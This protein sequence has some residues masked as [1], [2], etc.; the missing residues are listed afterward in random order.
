MNMF[1]TTQRRPREQINTAGNQSVS[2]DIAAIQAN[3]LL[4]EGD[5]STLQDDVSNAQ[6]D[7]SDAVQDIAVLSGLKSGLIYQRANTEKLPWGVGATIYADVTVTG[8]AAIVTAIVT[9]DRV[10]HEAVIDIPSGFDVSLSLPLGGGVQS[11]AIADD[12]IA[13][14]VHV[15]EQ[16]TKNGTSWEKMHSVVAYNASTNIM[17]A[18]ECYFEQGSRPGAN[19]P[20]STI[21]TS[22]ELYLYIGMT[23]TQASSGT[24]IVIRKQ[25]VRIEKYLGL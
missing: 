14:R 6:G 1:K 9:G 10:V 3:I 25:E 17:I 13:K 20:A 19:C 24:P 12:S 22:G 8:S 11:F 2:A 7:I 23:I 18:D 15:V 5:I 21:V 16:Y 4:I